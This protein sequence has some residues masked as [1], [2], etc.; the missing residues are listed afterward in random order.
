MAAVLEAAVVAP[1]GYIER[2]HERPYDYACP[3]PQGVAWNN[4]RSDARPVV[5]ADGRRTE[6]APAI[7]REGFMLVNAP[8]AVSDFGD[9][10]AIASVY[11]A[12]VA[13]LARAAVGGSAAYV[14]DHLV[15]R[16]E[17]GPALTF[18][19]SVSGARPSANGRVHND[20]TEMSG[21]RRMSQVLE[22]HPHPNP[23]PEGEG[24]AFL[25]PP[26]GEGR[27]GGGFNRYAIVNVWRPLE[28]PVLDAPLA[29]C[30]ARSVSVSDLVTSDV[31][32][33]A[34]TGEIYLVAHSP[35]H[36]WLYFPEMQPAEALV[37]KQ[38]DSDVRAPRFV[39]HAAFDHPDTPAEAPLRES[40]E[41]RVLV[42]FA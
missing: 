22:S 13:E 11:Y 2:Q 39:P 18:G 25:L 16:R 29:L 23:P 35:S 38:Y 15:R 14:F 3:P 10:A 37:F 32:Y 12:Q 4:Y 31:H 7:G 28:G 6:V 9:E 41:A 34:R 8:S 1:L 42:V 36:R 24:T 30:D 5:I 33:A 26:R 21:P 40:I 20:Y 19:R 27:D 17:A